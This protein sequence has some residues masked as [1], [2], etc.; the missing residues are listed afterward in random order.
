VK[1]HALKKKF[2]LEIVYLKTRLVTT[3]AI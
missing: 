3:N 1:L 2:G